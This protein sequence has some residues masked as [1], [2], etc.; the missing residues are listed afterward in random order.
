MAPGLSDAAHGPAQ[1]SLDFPVAHGLEIDRSAAGFLVSGQELLAA[2]DTPQGK[3]LPAEAPRTDTGPGQVLGRVAEVAE[4]P[5][6]DTH[7]PGRPDHQVA[8]TE[9]AV[10]HD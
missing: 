9:V 6:E 4:F 7:Q 2:A 1:V 5:V 10:D 3:V 8:D